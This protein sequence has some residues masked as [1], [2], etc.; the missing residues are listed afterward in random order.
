ME[1]G[2]APNWPR[3]KE[4]FTRFWNDPHCGPLAEITCLKPDAPKTP[5]KFSWVL[6]EDPWWWLLQWLTGPGKDGNATFPELLEKF[7][8]HFAAQGY[9][10][11]AYP[12]LFTNFGPGSLAACLTGFLQ[13]SKEGETSWFELPEPMAW[14]KILSLKLDPE[15]Y[16]W[17]KTL[18]LSRMFLSNRKDRYAISIIDLGGVMDIL[19]SLRT[20]LQLLEDVAAEPDL[21]LEAC[22]HINELW[23]QAYEEVY[24][25]HRAE[26]D[27]G[28]S[29]AWMGPWSPQR[30]SPLQADFSYMI[31]PKHF[32]KIEGP[33]LRDQC[34][35]LQ[36]SIY[37]W[38]GMGQIPHLDTLLDIP[39]LGGIQW[40]PGAGKPQWEDPQWY[41]LYDRIQKAGK[42]L[43]VILPPAE[44]V[45]FCRRFDRTGVF[46]TTRA[47]T[48]GQA[49]ELEKELGI[50]S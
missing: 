35:F 13:F 34:R 43:V 12:M 22:R 1:P 17:K 15:Q 41:P 3:T 20:S 10:G 50:H 30:W 47:E 33:I 46:V 23:K 36:H 2:L 21:V 49:R 44:V 6:N 7:D 24:Q 39:E 5:K 19:S 29:A 18:E 4:R 40:V 38:D 31:S 48:P 42:R 28:T 27:E 25:L 32:E 14:D 26:G 16:W 8:A 11:D 45:N 37:H 9:Y